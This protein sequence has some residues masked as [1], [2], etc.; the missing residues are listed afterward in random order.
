MS[1]RLRKGLRR[2]GRL[3]APLIGLTFGLASAWLAG[4]C[5]A[6][7]GLYIPPPAPD[8]FV[9]ADCEGIE[10]LC[11]PVFC[12][13][14]SQVDAG[15]GGDM[16]GGGEGE[17]ADAGPP[18]RGGVCRK[19]DP[20]DCDDNDECTAQECDSYTGQCI[21]NLVSFDIDGDGYRGP[22]VGTVAGELGSCGDDCDD[23]SEL[24]HPGGFE[25]CDGVDNDC[26]GI[27]DDNADFIP[28][29]KEP[30]RLSGDIDPAGPGGLAWSGSSYAAVYTGTKDGFAVF[31]TMLDPVG[32]PIPPGEEAVTIK[33]ADASGGP[34]VWVGD[35]YGFAWQDRRDGDYEVYF[36]ILDESGVKVHADTRLSNAFGFSVNVAL[37][38]TGAEFAVVW[39]DER[40]GLFN[41]YGQR[42]SVD[43][44]PIGENVPLTNPDGG[45]D[46]EGPSVAAGFAGIGVAWTV[47]DAYTHF[48]QFRT[49]NPDLSPIAPSISL[50]DGSTDSVYPTVVWNN[51]RY[52]IAWFDKTASPK[53][54]YAAAVSED[55]TLLVPPTPITEPGPFRSRYPYLRPLGDRLL[56]VYADDRDQNDGYELYSRMIDS[57]LVPVTPEK[58]LTADKMDSIYPIATFGPE[59]D[60][61]ILFRDDREA[62]EHHVYFMNLG[63]VANP[64]P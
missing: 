33:S 26:N 34:I 35:R 45:W 60:V 19:R 64:T 63:C 38:W 17:T 54:I 55:G 56:L 42:V 57:N 23:T 6:R 5:G 27:V 32:G 11:N 51:D 47:G 12:Q 25:V 14:F 59:G 44:E 49:Y 22:K 8:C 1:V 29:G 46:N 36:T 62:G 53:A 39:Q 41:L 50:T 28:T 20:V 10:D 43:S 13:L 3:R 58:R 7:T 31:R 37:T 16:G 48:I 15:A 4:A 30:I 9:D 2:A 21:Y 24:A 61:G 52:V 18:P 40:D